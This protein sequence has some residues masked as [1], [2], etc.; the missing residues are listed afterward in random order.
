MPEYSLAPRTQAA[1]PSP[2][3]TG[4]TP[5]SMNSLQAVRD[6]S[7]P[8]DLLHRFRSAH[9]ALGASFALYAH[10]VP[11]SEAPSK[12]YLLL[13]CDV[14][15]ATRIRNCRTLLQH[16][17]LK[18]ASR[19]VEGIC[20]S[21]LP[22]VEPRAGTPSV[23]LEGSGFRSAWLVPTHSGGGTGRFGL[24]C[25]GSPQAGHFESASVA[26]SMFLAKALATEL[27]EW[28]MAQTRRLLR[29]AA[30]LRLEDLRLLSMERD[31][32]RTKEIARAL[33]MTCSSVDSRFQRI[34]VKLGCASRKAAAQKA[35]CHGL[36]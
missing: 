20:T 1:L 19:Q 21:A 24:L 32:Y 12:T 34:N 5:H 18:Y 6:A 35:A 27:H 30:R 15:L 36:I 2:T 23:D 14:G 16:P 3:A 7:D 8:F 31:G 29:A 33:G 4:S 10:V 9:R 22:L 13:S 17:W 25:M 28:W 26:D 11:E